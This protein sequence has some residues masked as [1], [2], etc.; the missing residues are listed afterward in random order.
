MELDTK[1]KKI[2]I[3]E[4]YVEEKSSGNLTQHSP[5]WKL[6]KIFT[7]GG[8]TLASVLGINPFN[9]IHDFVLSRIGFTK[10][11][12]NIKTQ[13]GNLFEEIILRFVEYDCACKI[14]GEN[15]YIKMDG[16]YT[17]IAYSPDGLTV[18]N[19]IRDGNLSPEIVLLEFKCPYSRI[20]TGIVPK[21]YMPQVK[22]GLQ[23]IDITSSGL[24]VEAVF[25]MCSWDQLGEDCSY[26]LDGKTLQY[27]TKP[28][29]FGIMGFYYDTC[30]DDTTN[31]ACSDTDGTMPTEQDIIST[32]YEKEYEE[33]ANNDLSLCNQVLLEKLI[34]AVDVGQI[35][36]WYG[37]IIST[38]L[39]THAGNIHSQTIHNADAVPNTL[40]KNFEILNDDL[41]QYTKFCTGKKNLGILPWKLFQIDYNFIE[42]TPGYV[43]EWMPKITEILNLIKEC[44]KTSDMDE[45]RKIYSNYFS[46]AQN[47]GFSNE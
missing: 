35:S 28:L 20:P 10:F 29:A 15:L 22:L 36:I 47:G 25:R 16:K 37:S 45:R 8:S 44:H 40:E 26:I 11:S 3:L 30:S 21:Y 42:P 1:Q 17:G 7:V 12:G 5:G 2:A 34:Q 6:D 9:K 41:A 4:N 46:R 18:I 23:M 32:L 24:F 33:Y 38:M 31:D 27:K 14:L 39:P 13:W 43:D 19:R